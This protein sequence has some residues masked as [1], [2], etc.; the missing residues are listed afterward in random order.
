MSLSFANCSTSRPLYDTIYQQKYEW[1]SGVPAKT[2]AV[3]RGTTFTRFGGDRSEITSRRS[4][5]DNVEGMEYNITNR[6]IT[7]RLRSPME[8]IPGEIVAR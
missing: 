7:E 6:A 1:Y 5:I 3:M 8:V 2:V 4:T